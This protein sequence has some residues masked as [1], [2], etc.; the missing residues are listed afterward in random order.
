MKTDV[1]GRVKNVNL[2]TSRPLLPL[3]EAIVNSIQAIEDA[4]E[5]NGAI[6]IRL[7]RDD[8]PTLLENDKGSA[9]IVAFEIVDNG[10]GFTEENY[11]AFST[12]DT[13]YKADRGGK[14]I[15]RFVWLVAF[16]EVEIRS[17]F[18]SE[19]MWKERCFSF[20]AEGDGVVPGE[21]VDTANAARQT[22]V[23]LRGFREKFRQAAP[24]KIETIGAY[25]TEHCLEYL[26]RPNPP[27][28]KLVDASTREQLDLNDAFE[29]EMAHNAKAVPFEIGGVG[30]SILH[31]R[32]YSSHI[33]DHLLHYCAN[34]RVVKSER[35]SGRVPDLARKL[36]DEEGREFV[37]ASYLDSEL[38]NSTVTQERTDFS[39]ATEGADLISNGISW[40]EIREAA[41]ERVKEY[42]APYTKPIREE[43]AQRIERFVSTEAPMYRPILKYVEGD[44]GFL[45]SDIGDQELDLK[46]YKA[47]H[48]LQ[49]KLRVE[50]NELMNAQDDTC[51]EFD[52]FAAQ[53]EEYFT[54]IGDA[55]QADLARFVF[56]RR[57][58]LEFLQRLLGRRPDG[59]YSLES[60][61]HQLIFPMGKTSLDIPFERH[62]LWLLDERLAYHRFLASDKQ[63]RSTVPLVNG[64]QKELD[65]VV[66][67]KACAFS[68]ESDGPFQ[69]ITIIEFK[70]PMRTG[71]SEDDNPFDQ[72][73][74]YIEEIRKGKARTADGR[75]VPISGGVHFYCYVVADMTDK[76]ETH[77][78]KAELEKT[79]DN[80]GFFG[81]KKHYR[82]YIE[83]ISYTKLL[84]DAKQRNRVFFDAMGLPAVLPALSRSN[85]SAECA[86]LSDAS[87]V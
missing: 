74:E 15:G 40:P 16:D 87:R 30:F 13:T 84:T 61:V 55:N 19:A 78:Y 12:S 77:A 17:T 39:I 56:H 81:Y 75:D 4:G 59:K 23:C 11:L 42:L 50:G 24:K 7:I 32:L 41:N 25:I 36:R 73:L 52:K 58:V 45:D 71:Y 60:R 53:F 38:L 47:Y 70:R 76:I 5:Q 68:G 79:P 48:D 54:K 33:K 20:H 69:T 6:T 43:K 10:I 46:L 27:R 65:L 22:S 9:E 26:I 34:N 82:A 14:G 21:A 3:F 51:Q 1:A 8:S 18:Q 66:F 80:Q 62:N 64:S 85:S 44:I 31:V 86:S 67:D 29:R 37:Y 57:M 49:V 35:I 2:P 63:L 28:L 72:V 83:F